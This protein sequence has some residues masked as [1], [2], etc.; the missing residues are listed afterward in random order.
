MDRRR[1]RSLI[2]LAILL[3]IILGLSSRRLPGYLPRVVSLY[4]G[5]VLW[6]LAVYLGFIFVRSTAS[7]PMAATLALCFALLVEISQLYHAPWIDSIRAN[8]FGGL[9]LG[10]GF[11]WSDLVCY[12]VGIALG[13]I[14]D[15]NFRNTS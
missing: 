14:L 2:G 15:R 6:A 9:I 4:A 11:L 7:K 12:C 13:V 3:V 8:P 5:D 1:S 10:F